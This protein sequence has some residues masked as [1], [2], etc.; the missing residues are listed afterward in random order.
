MDRRGQVGGEKKKLPHCF[1]ET[2]PHARHQPPP[3]PPSTP[4]LT[5]PHTLYIV[6]TTKHWRGEEAVN[7]G[8]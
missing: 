2:S 7:I 6:K 4:K 5:D 1:R 8:E 3:P